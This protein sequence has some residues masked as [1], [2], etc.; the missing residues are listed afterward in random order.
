MKGPKSSSMLFWALDTLFCNK[1]LLHL[2][3]YVQKGGMNPVQ[4]SRGGRP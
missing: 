1:S 2:F 3:L 4:G